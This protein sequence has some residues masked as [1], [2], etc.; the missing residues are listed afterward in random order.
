MS[1]EEK[2]ESRHAATDPQKCRDM[3]Q[4]YGWKLILRLWL[5]TTAVTS[6]Y[7]TRTNTRNHGISRVTVNL[8][9]IWSRRRSPLGVTDAYTRAYS[10]GF[11]R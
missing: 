7:S 8:A 11:L 5:S 4:K 10:P 2:P 6:Y 1:R 3:E 9:P